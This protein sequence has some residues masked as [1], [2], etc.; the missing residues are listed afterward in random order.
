MDGLV[1]VA[2]GLPYWRA[3]PGRRRIWVLSLSQGIAAATW[4]LRCWPGW[5]FGGRQARGVIRDWAYSARH[6]RYPR[7][8]GVDPRPGL[9]QVAIPVLAVSV[10][11]DAFT[12]AS[13]VDYIAAKLNAAPVVRRHYTAAEAG[14]PL[15]HF[16]WVRAS[17]ALA[18]RIAAFA[19]T[20]PS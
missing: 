19:T 3:Y 15:D 8:G 10:E 2:V 4:A 13:T 7:L 16:G 11:G 20:P 12:P 14:A 1:L 18:D 6:G 17:A 9:A 5:G